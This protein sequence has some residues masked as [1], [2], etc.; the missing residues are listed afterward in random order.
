MVLEFQNDGKIIAGGDFGSYNGAARTKIARVNIDGSNDATFTPIGGFNGAVTEITLQPDNKVLVGGGF[1]TFNSISRSKIARL[2]SNGLLDNTFNPGTGF[3]NGVNSIVVLP[4]SRIIA[5]GHFNVFNGVDRESIACLNSDGTLDNSMFSG[6]LFDFNVRSV[7]LL[8]DGK[9]ITAGDFSSY[10]EISAQKIARLNADGSIDEEFNQGSGFER[11]ANVAAVLPDQKILVGGYYTSY[12]GTHTYGLARLH[13]DG[14]F[15]STFFHGADPGGNISEIFVLPD[16]KILI[17]GGF[18]EMQ[19]VMRYCIARLNEDGTVDTT[20]NPNGGFDDDVYA[21]DIQSDG[22]IIVGGRFTSFNSIPTNYIARLNVDG[23]LDTTFQTGTGFDHYVYDLLITD[24]NKILAGGSFTQYNGYLE[25]RLV[26]LTQDGFSDNLFVHSLFLTVYSIAEQNDNKFIIA[27][28]KIYRIHPDGE[29]D[30]TFD[31]DPTTLWGGEVRSVLVQDNGKIVIGGY[32]NQYNGTSCNG[33]A[34]LRSNGMLDTGFDSGSGFDDGVRCIVQQND[35][36]IIA[37]GD[38]HTYNN[39][40]RTRIA[41]IDGGCL[42]NISINQDGGTLTA[43]NA[44][45]SY[46]WVNCDSGFAHVV[47]ATQQS[48]TPVIEGN[49]AAIITEGT[50]QDT[51]NCIGI[52]GLE[53]QE[54][55]PWDIKFYPNPTNGNLT[56]ENLPESGKIEILTMPGTLIQTVSINDQQMKFDCSSLESGTYIVRVYNDDQIYSSTFI[57]LKSGY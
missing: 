55:D 23:S 40:C 20:F 43:A 57:V 5:G 31:S 4:D 53:I 56:F 39:F 7:Q 1:T 19:G 14:E 30:T 29:T 26:R 47:G 3:D 17:G 16:G 34:R 11:I 38:F 28:N 25:P 32:F 41:R 27:G 6:L 10:N 24:D 13:P 42:T 48:F 18:Y 50:C 33:I 36:S 8:S 45:A 35:S 22:K 15:D 51:S 37:V 21:I 54:T 9:L 2:N 12:N 52:F 44:G 46:Q 49:Y